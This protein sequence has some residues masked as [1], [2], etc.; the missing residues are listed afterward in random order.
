M[1]YL[2]RLD[3][4]CETM[5][6]ELWNKMERLL[7]KYE[8]CPIVGVIP[9]NKDDKLKIDFEDSKFW[10]KAK[11]WEAKDWGLAMHGYDHVYIS[12]EKGI[13]PVH[14]RSEFAGLDFSIQKEKITNGYSI[15]R[16]KGIFPKIFFAPS[17]TF[18]RNTLRALKEAT[19]IRIISD[20]IA[21]DIYKEGEFYFIPQQTGKVRKLPFSLVTFCYHPNDMKE[22]DF[23][24]LEEFIIKNKDRFIKFKDLELKNR[25]LNLYDKFLKWGYFI[26]RRIK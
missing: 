18:D 3:D 6:I 7:D 23:I 12:K 26:L 8:I 9:N 25:S 20:T 21:N 13:N 17:H 4:A 5:N 19:D 1:K 14:N 16:N 15:L 24:T 11:K 10:E 2:L 22:K